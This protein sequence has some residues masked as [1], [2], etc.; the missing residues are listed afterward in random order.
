MKNYKKP[1]KTNNK[2]KN[3]KPV[4][5]EKVELIRL[6][7]FIANSGICSRRQA[8]EHIKNGQITVNNE[9]VTDLGTKISSKDVVKYKGKVIK[10]QKNVYI[11]LNKPKDYISTLEDPQGRKTV[12]EFFKDKVKERIY[13]VGRL[14]RNTTGVLIFTNDGNLTRKLTHPEN[15][16]PKIYNVTLNKIVPKS[17]ILRIAD[18]IELDDGFISAD[19][20]YYYSEKDHKKIIVEI[21][22]GRNRIVRRIFEHLGYEVKNLDRVNFAGVTKKDLLRGQWR[23]LENKEIGF[24]IMLAGKLKNK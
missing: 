19:S 23:Y 13:P 16:I 15:Q 10:G 22:S 20:V 6:N 17:D 14:D 11:V 3:K 4:K 9:L 24:L 12:I 2:S 5:K 8:D 1:D 7:K 18:G 21:H